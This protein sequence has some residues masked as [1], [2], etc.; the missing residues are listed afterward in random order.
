MPETELYRRD[1]VTWTGFSLIGVWAFFLYFMG[2]AS[3]AIGADLGLGDA[4]RGLLS[5]ALAAGLTASALAGPRAIRRWGRRGT[6][7]RLLIGL[8]LLAL[9]LATSGTYPLIL[10]AVAGVGLLG[11][12]V[13]NTATATLSDHH[14]GH[15]ARAIT[16]GNAAASWLGVL[17]PAMLGFFLALPTGWRGAAVVLGAL[18]LLALIPVRRLPGRSSA[19]IASSGD[20]TG[21]AGPPRS[22]FPLAFWPA[23]VAV[24][25][26]VALEF[27]IN[28]WAA[29]LI[30]QRTGVDPS[31]AVAALSAVTLGMALG[32]TFLASA[33]NRYPVGALIVCFFAITAAGLAALLLAGTYWSSVGALFVSGLGLSLLF[34]FAQALAISLVEEGTDRAVALTALAVGLAVG[35]APFLL[36]V[37][38]GVVGLEG[39]LSTGFL[40]A[41][42]GVGG[43]A[44]AARSQPA[45]GR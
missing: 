10:L 7:V 12:T 40:L 3:T 4:A 38:A 31:A 42:A 45:A 44:M 43:T 28:F 5:T 24:S 6:L 35:A 1:R 29:A 23:L 2:P 36:G 41:A 18:P 25:M 16:E 9:A 32:R 33:S 34:P 15:R 8:A 22:A 13:A 11:A 27:S 19:P 20:S 17:S 37:L 39:A 21:P 26:A 14:P 30:S